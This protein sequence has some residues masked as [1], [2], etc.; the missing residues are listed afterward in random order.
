MPL[1]NH[2]YLRPYWGSTLLR[3]VLLRP[4]FVPSTPHLTCHLPLLSCRH[5][6]KFGGFL[7]IPTSVD[8][9]LAELKSEFKINSLDGAFEVLSS[10]NAADNST[11]MN[12]VI[13]LVFLNTITVLFLGKYRGY[14]ASL[15]R[16]RENRMLEDERIAAGMRSRGVQS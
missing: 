9:L 16:R 2:T 5:L 14:R 1:L 6:T 7:S 10:F 13:V 12:V 8:E 15:N 3:L 4:L 11:I